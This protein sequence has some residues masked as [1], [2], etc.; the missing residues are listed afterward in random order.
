M[1]LDSISCPFCGNKLR[2]WVSANVSFTF[3]DN[4]VSQTKPLGAVAYEEAKMEGIEHNWSLHCTM[5]SFSIDTNGNIHAPV[6]AEEMAN[7]SDA[8]N[9]VSKAFDNL[10]V[11]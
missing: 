6:E 5:C 11:I 9:Y 7:Y 2:A 4:T 1:N 3:K 10:E 8:I